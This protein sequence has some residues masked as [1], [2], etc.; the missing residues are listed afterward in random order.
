M[1]NKQKLVN[2][3]TESEKE[4]LAKQDLALRIAMVMDRTN[5][6]LPNPEATVND[7]YKMFGNDKKVQEAILFGSF[8][9]YGTTYKLTTQEIGKWIY[10]YKK[11]K[12]K[13]ERL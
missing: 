4:N 10:T 5:Q 2:S 13:V 6:I 7:I 3:Q 8:G 1:E 11:P 12:Y 9:K